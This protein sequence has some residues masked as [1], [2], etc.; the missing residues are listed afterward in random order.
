MSRGVK[1]TKEDIEAMVQ[2]LEP[3]LHRG[4]KLKTACYK[5]EIPYTTILD[6]MD[7][8]EWVR[9]KI[10]GA[11]ALFETVMNNSVF[12]SAKKDGRLALDV[13]SRIDKDRWSTRQENV[14]EHKI[15]G[16]IKF[17]IDEG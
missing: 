10:N 13:L 1:R 9:T 16:P 5:A 14:N 11:E 8:Y 12:E 3:L 6:Y 4:V 2:I 17:T 7:K 15:E